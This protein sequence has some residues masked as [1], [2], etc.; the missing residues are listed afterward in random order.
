MTTR[1][2]VGTPAEDDPIERLTSR[3][4]PP[5]PELHARLARRAEIEGLLDIAYTLVDSPVGPLLVACTSDGVVRVA[6][7]REGHDAVLDS[8]S[9]TISPRILRSTRRTD[10][11]ARQLDEYFTH[12]RRSFDTAV[13]LRLVTG[14]R[15]TVVSQLRD[16]PY[17]E[18]ATYAG[19]AAAAGKP[20]AVRAAASACSHNPI[21]LVVPCH[22]VLRTDGSLGGYLGGTEAKVALLELERTL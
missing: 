19:L 16:I 9:T 4:V 7:E 11:V 14:F 21:P 2:D 17:G 18:T 3:A 10:A 13:D 6:F 8:L 20:A 15:R 12:S 5:R 22:R 1:T